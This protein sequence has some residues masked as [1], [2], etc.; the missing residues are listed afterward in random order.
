MIEQRIKQIAKWVPLVI[1]IVSS[2]SLIVIFQ[3]NY[4]AEAF[5][6]R[7]VPLAIVV[8]LSSIAT[9]LSLRK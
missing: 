5:A 7:A 2:I 3:S 4:I 6:A 8:G 1:L 9:S